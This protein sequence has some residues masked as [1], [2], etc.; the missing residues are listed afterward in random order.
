VPETTIH[1]TDADQEHRLGVLK[2][3][4]AVLYH[5]RGGDRVLLSEAGTLYE[6]FREGEVPT[7][8]AEGVDYDLAIEAAIQGN[9]NGSATFRV[10]MSADDIAALQT[11]Q[12]DEPEEDHT[13]A[14]PNRP[15]P[16]S[17]PPEDWVPLISSCKVALNLLAAHNGSTQAAYT[18]VRIMGG[19]DPDGPWQDIAWLFATSF[20]TDLR[21]L[22]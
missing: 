14:I 18:W 2:A 5:L 13:A 15:L 21:Q 6:R 10:G 7:L 12:A 16:D 9:F 1:M 19:N 17:Q 22:S 8:I 11:E 3:I 20:P 4:R